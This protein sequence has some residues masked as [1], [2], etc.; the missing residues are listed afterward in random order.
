MKDV[1]IGTSSKKGK[2]VGK[3][4]TLLKLFVHS[5]ILYFYI[6][7]LCEFL[8]FPSVDLKAFVTYM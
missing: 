2:S 4:K 7:M 5:Y 1:E 3:F 6:T 8:D